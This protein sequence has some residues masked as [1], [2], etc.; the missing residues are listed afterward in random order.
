MPLS[1]CQQPF[2][3]IKKPFFTI[4]TSFFCQLPQITSKIATQNSRL[5]KVKQPKIRE[6]LSL[7]SYLRPKFIQWISAFA[8]TS[9]TF[10]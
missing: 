2:F 5:Y 10:M 6:H 1:S 9:S 8:T 7:N 3:T 4:K